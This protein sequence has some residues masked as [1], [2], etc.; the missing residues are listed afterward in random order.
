MQ[1]PSTKPRISCRRF[2]ERYRCM[3][4]SSP[5]AAISSGG[6]PGALESTESSLLDRMLLDR[7][8]A[9]CERAFGTNL[10]VVSISPRAR[11]GALETLN[12]RWWIESECAANE[13]STRIL[14][15]RPVLLPQLWKDALRRFEACTFC[16]EPVSQWAWKSTHEFGAPLSREG[17]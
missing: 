11:N 14:Q 15:P 8:G 4:T 16:R 17:G 1:V 2:A 12:P 5:I 7:I 9:R 10:A 6:G 13:P 3:G